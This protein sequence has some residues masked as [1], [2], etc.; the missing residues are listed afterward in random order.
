MALTDLIPIPAGINPGVRSAP[1]VTKGRPNRARA[2]SRA[3]T[4]TY[5]A[6]KRNETMTDK[7]VDLEALNLRKAP[8][9][10]SLGNRIGILHLGQPVKEIG[11]ASV[12]GWVKID[13]DING[14]SKRGVVKAEIDGMP[15]LWEALVAEAIKDSSRFEQGPGLRVRIREDGFF[16]L[17]QSASGANPIAPEGSHKRSFCKA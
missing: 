9:T 16:W 1:G 6:I 12:A 14:A 17:S 8:D 3:S 5:C 4:V 7:F 2:S 15:S 13:A 10:S 11:P